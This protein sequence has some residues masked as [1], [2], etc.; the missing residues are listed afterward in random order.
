[1]ANELKCKVSLSFEKGGVKVSRNASMNIDVT[2]NAYTSGVQKVP[3][4]GD[5]EALVESDELSNNIGWIY[6]KNLDDTNFA[7]F[8]NHATA[9]HAI[10]IMPG[11]AVL[12]RSMPAQLFGKA[13]TADVVIE[14]IMI[15]V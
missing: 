4:S 2:G 7:T 11:E 9:N 5:G 14:Y 13:D 12:F 8:G 3:Y 1:M 6:I 15:E 10:K